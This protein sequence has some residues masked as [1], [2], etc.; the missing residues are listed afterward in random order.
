[1]CRNV[2]TWTL[3]ASGCNGFS[4][5]V[6]RRERGRRRKL[7]GSTLHPSGI[8]PCVS[9]GAAASLGRNIIR[10]RRAARVE[11]NANTYVSY[12]CIIILYLIYT[13]NL[14]NMLLPRH[15]QTRYRTPCVAALGVFLFNFTN[16]IDLMNL[17]AH[18]HNSERNKMI[19]LNE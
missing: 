9:R 8:R 4:S 19:F 16:L 1:M 15:T 13:G 6:G 3:L 10:V 12:N 5:S 11:K 2:S 18:Y 7:D 14:V 17:G